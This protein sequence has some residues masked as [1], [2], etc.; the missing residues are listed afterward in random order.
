LPSDLHTCALAPVITQTPE[1][2][3]ELINV[4]ETDKRIKQSGCTVKTLWA[5]FQDLSQKQ[6]TKTITQTTNQQ[7]PKQQKQPPHT[8]THTK[9]QN[10]FLEENQPGQKG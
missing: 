2:T 7:K 9:T 3:N 5:A 10:T 1:H 6:K 4:I 8:H